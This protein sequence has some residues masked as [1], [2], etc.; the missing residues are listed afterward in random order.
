MKAVEY[1]L[2]RCRFRGE[3]GGP[4]LAGIVLISGDCRM[5]LDVGWYTSNSSAASTSI[6]ACRDEVMRD[7]DMDPSIESGH[8]TI[9]WLC[10]PAATSHHYQPLGTQSSSLSVQLL[11]LLSNSPMISAIE[12]IMSVSGQP[13][14]QR[15]R[16][17]IT[18]SMT[19][20]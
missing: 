20:S 4:F 14:P 11:Y 17:V 7:P 1:I 12:V 2:N 3:G 15:A 5:T 9:L 6:V 10:C 8:A 19:G 16:V 13:L 18:L